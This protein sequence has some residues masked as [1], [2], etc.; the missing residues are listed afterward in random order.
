MVGERLRS[1][2]TRDK[3]AHPARSGEK[4]FSRALRGPSDGAE[5]SG[6]DRPAVQSENSSVRRKASLRDRVT[7]DSAEDNAE[8]QGDTMSSMF[9]PDAWGRIR[10]Q[11][12]N[13]IHADGAVIDVAVDQIAEAV[14]VRQTRDG[15]AIQLD[16]APRYGG[17]RVELIWIGGQ[18][19]VSVQAT[20]RW[21]ASLVDKLSRA[22][23]RRGVPISRTRLV[24]R[25]S[26]GSWR[27]R[28][29]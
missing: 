25:D 4:G 17:G 26:F 22:L 5:R 24:E 29:R 20:A 2:L 1:L 18:I 27:R 12:S 7:S 21:N 3:S 6:H 13:P 10:A 16:L 11:P 8:E 9:T 15:T 14:S 28:A 23:G 19:V